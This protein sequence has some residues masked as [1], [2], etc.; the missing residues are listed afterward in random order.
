MSEKL[1]RQDYLRAEGINPDTDE[2]ESPDDTVRRILGKA[3]VDFTEG[4]T[5][6]VA[7]A[8]LAGK[9]P[10]V[11]RSLAEINQ[12]EAQRLAAERYAELTPEVGRLLDDVRNL[13]K[14]LRRTLTEQ[15]GS[16]QLVGDS[17]KLVATW[18]FLHIDYQR[19]GQGE[20]DLYE[21]QIRLENGK[22]VLQEIEGRYPKPEQSAEN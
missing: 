7:E 11:D 15:P 19:Y 21:L 1:S 17:E 13:N 5:P 3:D 12:A 18:N 8:R 9:L 2:Y 16:Q 4:I 6:A 22:Q 10:T 14:N 20:I